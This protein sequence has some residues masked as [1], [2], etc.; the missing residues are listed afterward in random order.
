MTLDEAL[1]IVD[2]NTCDEALRPYANDCDLKQA[3]VYTA[4]RV[5]IDNYRR[6][7]DALNDAIW[8]MTYEVY[9]SEEYGPF[10]E[11]CS[12][13]RGDGPCDKPGGNSGGACKK[14]GKC[15]C[16]KCSHNA[17]WQWRGFAREAERDERRNNCRINVGGIV[18]VDGT[19]QGEGL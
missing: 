7:F 14:C 10:C 18:G 6:M 17:K 19:R 3:K 4:R 1:K 13:G 5:V 12:G 16:A 2:P 8:D 9:W 11:I 15:R